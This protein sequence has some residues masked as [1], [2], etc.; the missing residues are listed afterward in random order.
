MGTTK[1]TENLFSETTRPEY[2]TTESKPKKGIVAKRLVN[3]RKDASSTS[4]SL[5]ALSRG[6][7]VIILGEVGDYY[8]IEYDHVKGYIRKDLVEEKVD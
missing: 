4:D 2:G 5:R 6:T 8:N 3:V 7:E 1:T